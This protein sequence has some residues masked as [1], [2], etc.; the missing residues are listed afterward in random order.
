[1]TLPRFEHLILK[2]STRHVLTLTIN[3][4]DKLNALNTGLLQELREAM[5]LVEQSDDTRV[6]LITGS[7]EKAF[8]AG[9]DIGELAQ[10]NRKSGEELARFGQEVFNQISNCSRAVIAVINGYALGGGAELAMACHIRLAGESARIGLPETGLGL[11]PG[12]GGTQRLPWL[13][14]LSR[15]TEMILTGRTLSAAE[16]KQAGLV[17]EVYPGE[18]LLPAARAM[19]NAIAEKGPIAIKKALEALRAAA[20]VEQLATEAKLFGKC[21]ETSDFREGT[22]AFLEKRK[23][24]FKNE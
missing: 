9:A 7:G 4:P 17:S 6:L 11:I 12:F 5:L 23:P 14:G 15:A 10:L 20:P 18:E 16:A 21:C 3:R 24:V 8:A 19:A 1:M 2:E 22:A 13:V